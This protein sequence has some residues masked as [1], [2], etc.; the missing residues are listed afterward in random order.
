MKIG[1]LEKENNIFTDKNP[2]HEKYINQG[3]TLQEVIQ[4]TIEENPS[5]ITNE[6]GTISPD[7]LNELVKKLS[8]QAKANSSYDQI[9][10][11][12]IYINSKDIWDPEQIAALRQD[13]RTR[14]NTI[15][16]DADELLE[17]IDKE[18]EDIAYVVEYDIDNPN[19]RLL[20]SM[21]FPNHTPGALNYKEYNELKKIRNRLSSVQIQKKINKYNKKLAKKNG[22]APIPKSNKN[23]RKSENFSVSPSET[24]M[25]EEYY[26]E[27]AYA[28]T[29]E[30]VLAAS[31]E[32]FGVSEE[33]IKIVASEAWEKAKDKPT[34]LWD[35]NFSFVNE[36]SMSLLIL[37]DIST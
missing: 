22:D 8:A 34:K 6:D 35:Y 15:I 3:I 2:Q 32:V 17:R 37:T 10:D 33:R 20:T 25:N 7:K 28:E 14:I 30:K 27:V 13:N 1:K 29:Y 4:K 21:L 19:Y 11:K 36:S 16:E 24:D 23:T 12:E 18:L 5:L 9:S 26:L 31:S